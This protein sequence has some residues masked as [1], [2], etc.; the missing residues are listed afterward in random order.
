MG[1]ERPVQLGERDILR[2]TGGELGKKK[3]GM[4]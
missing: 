3:R 4:Y 2:K 1:R